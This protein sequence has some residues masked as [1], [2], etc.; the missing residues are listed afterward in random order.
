MQSLWRAVISQAVTD[1]KTQPKNGADWYAR[2]MAEWFLFD[3]GEE[4]SFVCE[5]AGWSASRVRE[6]AR[7]ARERGYARP[8]EYRH[9]PEPEPSTFLGLRTQRAARQAEKERSDRNIVQDRRGQLWFEF[10]CEC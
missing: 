9:N 5:M 6:M 4:F 10:M 8:G 2:Y 3:S 7:Q 1:A